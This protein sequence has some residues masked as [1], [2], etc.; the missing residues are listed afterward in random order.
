MNIVEYEVRVLKP[1]KGDL[2]LITIGNDNHPA[3]AQQMKKMADIMRNIDLPCSAI[4]YNHTLQTRLVKKE[5][6]E[7]K[8]IH[9]K[10]K[11]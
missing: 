10:R 5:E 8:V 9:P 1:K 3:T 2:L 4:V 7:R 6:W 11:V